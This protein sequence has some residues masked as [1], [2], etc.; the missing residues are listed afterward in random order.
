MTLT[1]GNLFTDRYTRS[2]Y[3]I[4]A[5]IPAPDDVSVRR[6]LAAPLRLSVFDYR[7]KGANEAGVTL[8]LTH[9]TSFNKHLWQLVID[10]LL[11]NQTVKTAVKRILAIDASNHGDSAVL[12]QDVL[13]E[14]GQSCHRSFT[15]P[16]F[17]RASCYS[18]A[19]RIAT[20]SLKCDADIIR[21]GCQ[22]L[23]PTTQ[24]IYC[25]RSSFVESRNRWSV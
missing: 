24:E 10:Y 6:N 11:A 9:G 14:K 5:S 2:T 4:P 13:P 25:I 12:N 22:H 15:R 21:I 16:L 18:C 19:S 20:L 23:G 3:V 17:I 8:I 1:D 7:I